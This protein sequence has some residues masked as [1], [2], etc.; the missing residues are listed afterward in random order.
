MIER[1]WQS[2][3][4]ASSMSALLTGYTIASRY[5]VCR[6][7]HELIFKVETIFHFRHTK[8]IVR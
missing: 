8:S 4:G 5:L 1:P 3:L 2:P 6:S 7:H